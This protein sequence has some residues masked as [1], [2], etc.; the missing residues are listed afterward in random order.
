MTDHDLDTLLAELSTDVPAMTDEAFDAGRSR[1]RGVVDSGSLAVVT[2]L[3]PVAAEPPRRGLLRGPPR[4]MTQLVAA[5]AAVVAVGAGVVLVRDSGPITPA[6]VSTPEQLAEWAAGLA[7]DPAP[8]GPGQFRYVDTRYRDAA[9]IQGDA[10]FRVETALRSE[11]WIPYRHQDDW[12]VRQTPGGVRYL[13]GTEAEVVAA[14]YPPPLPADPSE[15][16]APCG[17]FTAYLIGT[18]PLTSEGSAQESAENPCDEDVTLTPEEYEHYTGDP[19]RL[20]DLIHE[21]AV[22]RGAGLRP[23]LVVQA[24][25]LL[26]GRQPNGF[27]ATVYQA[28]SKVPDL[29][30]LDDART[31]DGRSGIGLRVAENG[32]TELWILDRDTGDIIEQRETDAHFDTTRT[33]TYGVTD[34]L[35]ARPAGS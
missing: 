30:V 2:T 17:R 18:G 3:A 35:G 28:M 26:D 32:T 21:R 19:R 9:D 22:N 33:F 24:A 11:T 12:K 5:A 34:E 27:E 4:R 16:V 29:V 1:L 20:Y 6:A 10:R 14:G 25:Q 13:K 31:E 8:V 23:E 15:D 7:D